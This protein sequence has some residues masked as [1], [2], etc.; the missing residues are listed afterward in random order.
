MREEENGS[1]S[2]K[3]VDIKEHHWG[4]AS[5]CGILREGFEGRDS[6]LGSCPYWSSGELGV[7]SLLDFPKPF[8]RDSNQDDDE[9]SDDELGHVVNVPR[10]E[11]D[12]IRRNPVSAM[13]FLRS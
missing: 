2:S 8:E 5:W 11:D 1:F 13:P 9:A 7:I 10:T 4:R 6:P 12:A 3:S